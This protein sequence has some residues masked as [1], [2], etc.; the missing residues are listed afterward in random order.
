MHSQNRVVAVFILGLGLLG[1][2]RSPA[3]EPTR[4]A[5]SRTPTCVQGMKVYRSPADVPVPHDTVRPTLGGSAVNGM[6]QITDRDSFIR[7]LIAAA[8]RLGATGYVNYSADGSTMS[9]IG[10]V[11]MGRTLPVFVAADSAA[12]HAECRK[13]NGGAP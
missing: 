6:V 12:V 2:V 7:E 10:G 5:A 8:A 1:P 13:R 11:S 3:Q 9:S 4:T